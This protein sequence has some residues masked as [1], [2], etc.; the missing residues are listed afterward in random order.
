MSVDIG[1]RKVRGDHS[2]LKTGIRMPRKNKR[3]C[4]ESLPDLSLSLDLIDAY[5][6]AINTFVE[7]LKGVE[8][9]GGQKQ[10]IKSVR[11]PSLQKEAIAG[12]MRT[13][14]DVRWSV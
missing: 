12:P 14:F 11:V 4:V 1:K 3:T 7:G 9:N 13:I 5:E 6:K 10:G 2:G 8:L